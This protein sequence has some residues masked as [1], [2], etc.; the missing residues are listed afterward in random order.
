MRIGLFGGTFNPIHHGH[1][2][3][4]AEIQESFDL[5]KL[6]LIP[7]ALPPHKDLKN[8]IPAAERIEMTR[9]AIQDYPEFMLSD[10]ELKRSGPS[11]TVDTVQAFQSHLEPGS[12]LFLIMGLDAFLEIDTWKSYKRLVQMLPIIVMAR[13]LAQS[14]ATLTEWSVMTELI[15]SQISNAYQYSDEKQC[16]LHEQYQPIYRHAVSMLD[17]SATEIR[18]LVRQKRSIRFLVPQSVENYILK[19]GIYA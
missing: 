3:A 19:Q 18:Q 1:L 12:D 13:P 14:S 9:L 15:H 7:A 16:Y 10:V 6:Y 2:R 8:V 17:I 11:Y 4:A 5:R